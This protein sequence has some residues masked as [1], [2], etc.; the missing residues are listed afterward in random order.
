MGGFDMGGIGMG[1]DKMLMII[2]V[3]LVIGFIFGLVTIG[4]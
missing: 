1:I 3:G 4:I 2:I